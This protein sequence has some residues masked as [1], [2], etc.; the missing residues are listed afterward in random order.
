MGNSKKSVQ[1]QEILKKTMPLWAQSPLL[2]IKDMWNLIPQP[3]LEEYS[4]ALR[5]CIEQNELKSIKAYWFAPFERGLHITWQQYLILVAIE[6]ALNDKAPRRI[7]I[8]SGH[9][10]GKSSITSMILIWYL[11]THH[12]AQI[13][14]TAPTSRQLFD[15][16]WKE[17]GIWISRL[18][19]FWQTKFEWQSTYIRITE[20]PAAWFASA[21]TAKKDSTE[22][23]AG[24]HGQHV[25][26][27][28]DEAS[29]VPTE[30]FNTMEGSLTERDV[31][32]LLISNPTR[33]AGYFYDSHHKMSH[34]FQTLQFSSLDSPLP[35]DDYAKGIIEQHGVNSD[36]YRIRVLGEFPKEDAVDDLGYAPLIPRE[37][38]R[39][40]SASPT[41]QD[42]VGT[43]VMGVD[44]AGEGNDETRWVIRDDFKARCVATEKVSNAKG[45]AAKTRTL[46]Q[47]F[48]VKEEN[49]WVDSFGVGA[50]A[51]MEIAKGGV[52]INALNVGDACKDE[53]DRNLYINRRAQNYFR[54]RKWLISGAE[55]VYDKQWEAESIAIKYR[56]NEKGKIQIMS[57]KDMRREGYPS[58][59]LMD[60]LMLT[61]SEELYNQQIITYLKGD[62]NNAWSPKKLNPTITRNT[63][64]DIYS[65]I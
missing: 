6:Q 11:F 43:V 44:P 38:I 20:N 56:R 54:M 55:L 13:A 8:S 5:L 35:K 18:P 12:L 39:Q 65:A 61:F 52:D 26:I 32:V 22:A 27:L 29:G 33:N 40:I 53:A 49:V 9:G 24:V 41:N 4:S 19:S 21:K 2:F 51:A 64:N 28:C 23:L 7:S 10:I 3:P 57:K 17:V 58:P 31:L 59:N 36:E 1:Y 34:R 15:V 37:S 46:M 14:C 48:K 50:E 42:F 47:I 45:I 60:A 16:L 30:V 63:K 25:A 62:R